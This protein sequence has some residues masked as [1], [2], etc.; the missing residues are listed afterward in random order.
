MNKNGI[1]LNLILCAMMH[2]FN[3]YLMIFFK[4]MYPMM[5]DYFGLSMVGDI[6]TRLV[7]AYLGYGLSNFLTGILARKYSLKMLLFFGMLLM[8][9]AT[10]VFAFI[11]ADMYFLA[12]ICVFFIGLGGGTYHPAANTLMTSLYETKPGYAIGILSIGSAIGFV[13]APFIGDF[14][15]NKW[16]GFQTLFLLSGTM[17][18]VFNM[19]FFAFAK[20]APVQTS[21]QKD[22]VEKAGP[23][24]L[25]AKILVLVI[26]LLCIPSMIRDLMSW[27]YFEIT[28]FWVEYGFSSAIGIWII[29]VMAYLPGPVVQPISGWLCDKLGPM[30]VLIVTFLMCTIGHMLLAVIS[31]VFAWFG[32]VLYGI[33]MSA[34]TVASETYMASIV[35][36][37]NRTLVYGIVLSIAL[38]V[39]G[40][41]GGA[42]G[43]LVDAFGKT[44]AVGYQ[45]WFFGM[46]AMMA[47]SAVLYPV[48]QRIRKNAAA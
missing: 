21:A 12:V 33:G 5:A 6:T 40:V 17:V 29:Q 20:D 18:F 3:H 23:K 4:P 15:G 25:P 45:I 35:S 41:L 36:Q 11:P 32:L 43:W 39:G 16:L 8:S 1:R 48:I 31:P 26:L 13:A 19:V 28:P 30:R 2:G 14:V 22:A 47:L 10:V 37:K 27:G 38:G 24:P 44:N 42:S 34:S 7:V 46:G 9:T